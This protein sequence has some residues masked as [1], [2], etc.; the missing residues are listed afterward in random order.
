MAHILGIDVAKAKLDVALCRPDGKWR[1][2]VV[3]NT[4]AGFSV[5]GEWLVQ[6]GV[7]SVHACLEATGTYWEAVAE[8]LG[9][10][11][12]T[13]SVVNPAQIK[14]FGGAGAQQ[15]RSHRCAPDRGLLC[16][17]VSTAVAGAAGVGQDIT[18]PGQPPRGA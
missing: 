13:V 15:D 12:H 5:L 14:A 2:K 6:H 16:R 17:P 4:P 10:A 18:C 11:G 3:E 9:D 8:F 1:N 7:E